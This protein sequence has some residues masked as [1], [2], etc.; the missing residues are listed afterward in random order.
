MV[1][2]NTSVYGGYMSMVNRVTCIFSLLEALI[3]AFDVQYFQGFAFLHLTKD[4][5]SI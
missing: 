1:Y 3:E 2:S 5:D 4:T